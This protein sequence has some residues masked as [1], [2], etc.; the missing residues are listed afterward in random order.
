MNLIWA[1]GEERIRMGDW[2][3]TWRWPTDARKIMFW[4]FV[5]SPL[6]SMANILHSWTLHR[7]YW[8]PVWRNMLIGPLSN[9]LTAVIWGLAASHLWKGQTW[10]RGSA[11]T[12]SL[13]Y[14][15]M[16]FRQFIVPVRPT[17]SHGL[18][19]LSIGMIGLISFAWPD[20]QVDLPVRIP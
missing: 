12:A 8:S 4:I 13:L 2:S 20:K 16:Y 14:L 18:V 6:L 5:L 9:A 19:T 11:I 7:L 17:W 3:L 10:A 15:V 1:P